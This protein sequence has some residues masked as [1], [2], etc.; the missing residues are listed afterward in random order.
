MGIRKV[1]PGPASSRVQNNL[2]EL[3][4]A[5]GLTLDQLADRMADVGRPVLP[6]GLSKIEQ[7]DRRV[8]VDDL[9]ALAV[10]LGVN[11]NRLLLSDVAEDEALALTPEIGHPAWAVWQWADGF[12][13]LPTRPADDADDPYNTSAE[14][15]EFQRLAR[16]GVLRRTSQHPLMRAATDL[17]HRAR[18]VIL[19]ATK[20]P[21]PA[22]DR[23]DLGFET[24]LSLARHAVGRVSQELDALEEEHQHGER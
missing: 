2:K 18:R 15:E 1:Q 12:Y 17:S 7:G 13:P 16:P 5:A 9:V 21:D 3:R 6:S 10:A 23:P 22:R 11:V 4:K 20:A 19:H 8:D 14:Y 24:T